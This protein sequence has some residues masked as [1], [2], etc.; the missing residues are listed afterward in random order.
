MWGKFIKFL[1]ARNE[2]NKVAE[3]K[4]TEPVEIES[5]WELFEDIKPP[6]EVVLCALYVKNLGWIM[7]TS[8]WYE[9]KKCWMITGAVESLPSN[10]LYTHW[11]RLHSS[12]LST[13]DWKVFNRNKPPNRTV[14]ATCDSYD[15]GVGTSFDSVVWECDNQCWRVT[16]TD[17]DLKGHMPYT[18]W[19]ELPIHPNNIINTKYEKI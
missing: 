14:L 1:T 9:D 8:W 11:K 17:K 3:I 6:H 13:K 12:D 10:L 19:R 2:E 18:H 5:D 15:C 16:G 4:T 7:D